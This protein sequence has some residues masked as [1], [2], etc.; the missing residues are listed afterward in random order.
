MKFL[1]INGVST[2]YGKIK[3]NFLPYKGDGVS[4]EIPY[5]ESLRFI[6]KSSEDDIHKDSYVVCGLSGMSF[7]IG[8]VESADDPNVASNYITFEV[9]KNGRSKIAISNYDDYTTGYDRLSHPKTE[10]YGDGY[11]IMN[12]HN[13]LFH[14]K[15][16]VVDLMQNGADYRINGESIVPSAIEA[17]WLNSNLT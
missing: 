8:D 5:N 6:V 14:V 11:G 17:S 7:V 10:I 15:E 12:A 9:M 3:S 16:N 1:D 4:K 2:L 13:W